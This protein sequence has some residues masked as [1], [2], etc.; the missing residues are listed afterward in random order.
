MWI[1]SEISE[2]I[3]FFK[4]IEQHRLWCL[5]TF[6][7]ALQKKFFDF[8]FQK[9][10]EISSSRL[11]TNLCQFSYWQLKGIGQG[12]VPKWPKG[13]DCKSVASCFSGSNP[14]S[15]TTIL[16]D[17]I[18]LLTKPYD[19]CSIKRQLYTIGRSTQVAKGGRL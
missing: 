17:A 13:A 6:K 16:F 14:L 15:S 4:P 11:Y 9:T 7:M 12:G 3:F 5:K 1:L 2:S 19:C 18:I 8:I 10:L